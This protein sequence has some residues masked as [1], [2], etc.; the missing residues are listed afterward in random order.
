[1]QQ[2]GGVLIYIGTLQDTLKELT[3]QYNKEKEEERE[4]GG[5]KEEYRQEEEKWAQRSKTW[6]RRSS[7]AGPRVSRQILHWIWGLVDVEGTFSNF[8]I[9]P[10]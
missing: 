5:E 1:M 6:E 10:K 2:A 7:Y 9:A 8:T 3:V 4:G